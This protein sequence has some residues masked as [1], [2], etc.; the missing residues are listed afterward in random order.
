MGREGGGA[1]A[2]GSGSKD[3]VA[4]AADLQAL[5]SRPLFIETN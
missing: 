2:E 1:Q 5:S 4:A 3:S